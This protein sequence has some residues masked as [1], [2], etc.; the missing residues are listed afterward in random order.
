MS[1]FVGELV[2]KVRGILK[3][4]DGR[5]IKET[6]DS[7]IESLLGSKTPEDEAPRQRESKVTATRDTTPKQVCSAY[8]DKYS[9]NRL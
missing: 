1:L 4:A 7:K 3:W 6:I 2:G 8:C 5:V 9:G